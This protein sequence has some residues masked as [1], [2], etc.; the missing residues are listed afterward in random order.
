MELRHFRYFCVVAETLNVSEASRR[1]RIG[2]PSLSRQIRALERDLG[3]ALF[4]REKGRLALTEAGKAFRNRA[5]RVIT[6][7]DAVLADFRASVKRG[8]GELRIGYYGLTWATLLSPALPRFRRLFPSLVLSGLELAPTE[9]LSRLRK[10]T[11][12]LGVLPPATAGQTG[13]IVVEKIGTVPALVAL[14]VDHPLAKRRKLRLHDL[15]TEPF[16][17]YAPNL[18]RGRE[19]PLLAACRTA[20]FRP[21]LLRDASGLPG[22]LLGVAQNRG[23]AV[24]TPFARTSPH[25][26]VVFSQLEPPGVTLDLFVGYRRDGSDAARELAR[27]IGSENRRRGT[28]L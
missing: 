1:L 23:V 13:N 25:P 8:S 27:L 15:R 3:Q 11:L 22:L 7:F 21:R 6:D 20:G 16:L 17:S 19:K 9:I 28:V 26:G 10:G 14:S 2:Q 18:A 12:D 24:V 5:A 4:T